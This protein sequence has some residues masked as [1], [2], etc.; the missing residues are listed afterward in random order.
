[1]K[2]NQILEELLQSKRFDGNLVLKP[3]ESGTIN[4]SYQLDTQ[5]NQYFL[6]TFEMNHYTPV[7]RQAPYFLQ[8]KLAEHDRA[9][10]PCYLSRRHDFQVEQW[11]EHTS[12]AKADISRQDKIKHLATTLHAIHQLPIYASSIDLPADWRMYITMADIIPDDDLQHRLTR[13][14]EAWRESH[15]HDQ[16]LCHN[17]LAMEHIS[18]DDPSIVFDWEYAACGNRYFDIAACAV[19]NHLNASE[20]RQLQHDYA[21]KSQIALQNVVEKTTEQF[22]LVKLTNE[23]WY[24]AAGIQQAG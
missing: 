15:Q 20:T 1:M 19:I 22:P 9:A 21:E 17:D 13:C 14:G 18:I 16:V 4:R 7:D 5:C 10:K 6:K 12:L 23:L 24:L 3:I 11:V 8:A 2:Q